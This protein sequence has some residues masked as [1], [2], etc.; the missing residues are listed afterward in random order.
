[1]KLLV[2]SSSP[3]PCYLVPLS[4]KHPILKHPQPTFLPQRK[5]GLGCVCLLFISALNNTRRTTFYGK[6]SLT[7]RFANPVLGAVEQVSVIDPSH[8]KLM[9]P[10]QRTVLKVTGRCKTQSSKHALTS[11]SSALTHNVLLLQSATLT[12]TDKETN[13]QQIFFYTSQL[14]VSATSV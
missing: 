2:M 12:F 4:P 11:I 14:R 6:A 3:F 9:L 13:T 8:L 1:M 5:R 7:E 10:L